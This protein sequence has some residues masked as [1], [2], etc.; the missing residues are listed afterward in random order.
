MWTWIS[1]YL[2]GHEYAVARVDGAM[3]LRCLNCGRRSSGWLVD[4]HHR[5]KQG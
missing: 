3:F 2:T 4:A 5:H 1:C